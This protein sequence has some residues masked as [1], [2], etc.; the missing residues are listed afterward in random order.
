MQKAAVM[1]AL[2]VH[3]MTYAD[4]YSKAKGEDAA[5]IAALRT[6]ISDC[7]SAIG[8]GAFCS[9]EASIEFMAKIP[10]EIRLAM[11]RAKEGA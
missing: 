2:E 4:G 10:G 3:Q 9:P 5:E 6:I 7:A 11:A 1:N 8:N